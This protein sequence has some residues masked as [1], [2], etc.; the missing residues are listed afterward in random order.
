MLAHD[1]GDNVPALMTTT[2]WDQYLR[3]AERPLFPRR[4]FAVYFLR[5]SDEEGVAVEEVLNDLNGGFGG[6]KRLPPREEDREPVCV[7]VAQQYKSIDH[8][9]ARH[10][11]LANEEDFHP[12]YLIAV[13]R[14][15][16]AEHNVLLVDLEGTDGKATELTLEAEVVGELV[17]WIWA[18][19]VSVEEIVKE[20]NG[21]EIGPAVLYVKYVDG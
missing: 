19:L 11:Q 15:D 21:G 12:R 3:I 1:A 2:T 17:Q 8:V 6:R 7:A 10:G 18:G 5:A 14:E 16:W 9:K 20:S 4:A 13:R